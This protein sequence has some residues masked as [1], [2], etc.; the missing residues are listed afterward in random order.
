MK[1]TL[2]I[3][4]FFFQDLVQAI[5]HGFTG[6]TMFTFLVNMSRKMKIDGFRTFRSAHLFEIVII[7]TI[8]KESIRQDF[9]NVTSLEIGG[10]IQN[11]RYFCYVAM[12]T[13]CKF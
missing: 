1:F 13:F 10:F 11:A 8:V 6:T 3:F 4:C 12:E 7:D 9:H 5:E 2:V